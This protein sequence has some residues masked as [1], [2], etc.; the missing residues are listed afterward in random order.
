VQVVKENLRG[1]FKSNDTRVIRTHVCS[2]DCAKEIASFHQRREDAKMCASCG[3]KTDKLRFGMCVDGD[4]I[5]FDYF[6]LCSDNCFHAH[7]QPANEAFRLMTSPPAPGQLKCDVCSQDATQPKRCGGCRQRLYCSKDCQAVDWRDMGHKDLCKRLADTEHNTSTNTAEGTQTESTV[8][9]CE[10]CGRTATYS[11][12]N[13]CGRADG[14]EIYKRVN[15]CHATA[16][17]LLMKMIYDADVC[18]LGGASLVNVPARPEPMNRIPSEG[19]GVA[20][21]CTVCGEPGHMRCIHCLHATYCSEA[22]QKADWDAGH[23]DLCASLSYHHGR[24]NTANT[25]PEADRIAPSRTAMLAAAKAGHVIEIRFLSEETKNVHH[26]YHPRTTLGRCVKYIREKGLSELPPELRR[27][28]L[29]PR[30]LNAKDPKAKSM[31]ALLLHETMRDFERRLRHGNSGFQHRDRSDYGADV[32]E[33]ALLMKELKLPGVGTPDVASSIEILLADE[34]SVR[35]AETAK[36]ELM[37]VMFPL[38][39]RTWEHPAEGED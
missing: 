38:A 6:Y 22:C 26:I 7:Q 39:G 25:D 19:C 29:Q 5:A 24:A 15:G 34:R 14:R 20:T 4:R 3:R 9:N 21:K 32:L 30:G 10:I 13:V 31:Y 11:F 8:L 17:V 27:S 23:G 36:G 28:I 1:V 18:T 2:H 16:C 35:E 37:F 12:M 33:Y